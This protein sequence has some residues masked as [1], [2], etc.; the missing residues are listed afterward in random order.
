MQAIPLSRLGL[1]AALLLLT[2]SCD[3]PTP[4]GGGGF[5]QRY[6][7]AREALEGGDYDRAARGFRQLMPEAGALR[8]RLELE[9]AHSALR[10]GDYSEAARAGAA[11][12][13]GQSGA[14]RAA[15][16]AVQGTAQHE[17][18]LVLLAQGRT[19]EAVALL[20]AARAALSEV[21][22]TYPDLDPLGSMAGRNAAIEARL[23]RL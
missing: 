6:M 22:G 1:A 12:A 14:S 16:L 10:A 18:A 3:M 8:P 19:P 7:F 23:K 9:Y 4:S 17:Q 21:V 20:Q 15:A 5:Q 11:L 13:A 2:G